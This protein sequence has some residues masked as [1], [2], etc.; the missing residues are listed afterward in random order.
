M[1]SL[2]RAFL[3]CVVSLWLLPS[4]LSAQAVS[5]T[6]YGSVVDSSQAAVPGATVTVRNVNTNYSR[7][8]LTGADGE[9]RFAALPLGKY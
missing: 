3:I 4:G 7:N 9:Y 5:G 2:S 6:I 8:V 1:L